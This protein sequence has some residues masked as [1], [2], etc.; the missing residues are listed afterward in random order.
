MIYTTAFDLVKALAAADPNL[1]SSPW[2][3]RRLMAMTVWLP[4][5]VA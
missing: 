1:K 4:L 5:R 2:G 3:L